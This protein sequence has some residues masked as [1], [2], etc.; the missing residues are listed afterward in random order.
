MTLS[1]QTFI[2][3]FQIHVRWNMALI[4]QLFNCL[5]FLS[6]CQTAGPERQSSDQVCCCKGN[7]EVYFKMR[8]KMYQAKY[9]K[10]G[11]LGEYHHFLETNDSTVKIFESKRNTNWNQYNNEMCESFYT[12][13]LHIY[14]FAFNH[15]VIDLY[16]HKTPL[17]LDTDFLLKIYKFFYFSW[18]GCHVCATTI[19]LL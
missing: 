8:L 3:Y 14:F 9:L 7:K 13:V 2:L 6:A 17:I 11:Q 5:S 10:W 19:A 12:F 15:S 4:C 1:F 18:C 16:S